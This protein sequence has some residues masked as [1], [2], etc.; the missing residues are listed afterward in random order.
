MPTSLNGSAPVPFLEAQVRASWGGSLTASADMDSSALKG[1][2]I[3]DLIN[4]PYLVK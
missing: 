2:D 4:K 1:P 3:A